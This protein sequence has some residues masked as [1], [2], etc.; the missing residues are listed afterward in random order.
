MIKGNVKQNY[1]KEILQIEKLRYATGQDFFNHCDEIKGRQAGYI[2][3]NLE[4]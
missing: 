1:N 2:K 4:M 3:E